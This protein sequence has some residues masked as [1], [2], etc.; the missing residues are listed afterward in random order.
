M[1]KSTAYPCLLI[2]LP[3]L[4]SSLSAQNTLTFQVDLTAEESVDEVGLRGNLPPLLWD[5]SLPLTDNDGD[6]IYTAS[7]EFSSARPGDT[8]EYKFL[9]DEIWERQ[10][11]GNHKVILTG[12]AQTLPISKWK[13]YSEEFL[14][15]R[16]K[17]LNFAKYIF[18]YSSGKKRGLS[19]KEIAQEVI[20]FYSWRPWSVIA[21][22]TA[23]AILSASKTLSNSSTN[24]A[25]AL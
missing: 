18:I 1:R 24:T 6:G 3:F 11:T 23:T 2:S 15:E 9:K 17:S 20:D 12:Q 19:P 8:L 10:D 16:I 7:I 14:F 5:T 25:T 4:F 21:T 13:L 22:R